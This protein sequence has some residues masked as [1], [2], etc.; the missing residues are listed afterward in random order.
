MTSE[1][2]KA[3]DVLTS[4]EHKVDT[5]LGIVRTLEL[6]IRIVSNKLND[7]LEKNQESIPKI[8]V[9]AVD[10]SYINPENKLELENNPKGFRRTSRPETFS[11]DNSYLQKPSEVKKTPEQNTVLVPP[12]AMKNNVFIPEQQVPL[13]QEQ[14]IQNAIPT[15]Q[16]IVDRNGKSV[17]LADV[18]IIE[19]TTGNTVFKTRTNG[20]GKWMASLAIGNYITIVRKRESVS[21]EKIEIKQNIQVD[22]SKSPL[23][24]STLIIK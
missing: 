21:K 17:F 10:V 12:E 20:T 23:E 11:G 8:K 24:L 6:N 5:L 22:G 9:E 3:T 7:L 18:E 16:R 19:N 2:R 13:K 15:V 14:L 1:P 4:L